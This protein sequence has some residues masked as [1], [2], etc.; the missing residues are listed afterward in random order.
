[1]LTYVDDIILCQGLELGHYIVP[2]T[3]V[4]D[5]KGLNVDLSSASQSEHPDVLLQN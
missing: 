2:Q 5:A 1:M 4:E 3:E